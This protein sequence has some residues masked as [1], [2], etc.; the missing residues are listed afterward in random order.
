V[1]GAADADSVHPPKAGVE[2][3]DGPD[4]LG[5][6]VGSAKAAGAASQV[7]AKA[8]AIAPSRRDLD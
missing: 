8:A 3:L 5:D 1:N 6:G 4:G 7:T 2:P